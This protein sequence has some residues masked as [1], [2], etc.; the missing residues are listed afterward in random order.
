M[1]VNRDKRD[2]SSTWKRQPKDFGQLS[3]AFVLCWTH[4]QEANANTQWNMSAQ[5]KQTSRRTNW[6]VLVHVLVL[7]LVSSDCSC[8][9]PSWCWHNGA[10]TRI[11]M[12][13]GCV[14][15]SVIWSSV[16]MIMTMICYI[17]QPPNKDETAGEWRGQV[18]KIAYRA[19][20][21][22]LL[23]VLKQLRHAARDNCPALSL[24]SHQCLRQCRV[25]HAD[26]F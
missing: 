21:R 9:P 2:F 18:D 1:R 10:E 6:A 11:D 22:V 8:A 19:R 7:R 16:I 23:R 26:L 12:E 5:M 25:A 24:L 14:I 4:S 20:A 15:S 13:V 3:L 17:C